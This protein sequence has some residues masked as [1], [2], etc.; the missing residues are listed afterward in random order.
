MKKLKQL[1]KEYKRKRRQRKYNLG[2]YSYF[3]SGFSMSKASSVGKFCSIANNVQ[4]GP[5]RHPTNW[6]STHRFQYLDTVDIPKHPLIPFTYVMPCHIGNDVWIGTNAI[7][8]DGV[9]VGDGAIIGAGGVVTKDVPPYAIVGGVPAKI[10]RYRFDE[11][12]IADLLEL[13]WW[14]L[15]FEIIK[16]LPF[17]DIQKCIQ[18]RL[19]P[20]FLFLKTSYE[21]LYHYL[22]KQNYLL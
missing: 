12:T 17:D 6:L 3:G 14:D 2:K 18:H 8:L 19:F 9:N 7:I 21:E 13:K 15:D 22:L 11:K 20:C 4:I 16:T 5:T 10:I 1:F